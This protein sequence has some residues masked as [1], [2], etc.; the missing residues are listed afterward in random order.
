MLRWGEF[1][2]LR[3]DLAEAGRR[4]AEAPAGLA[5]QALFE[6]LVESCLWTATGGHGDWNPRHTVWRSG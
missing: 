2:R 6:F 3:P 4:L 5:D 1:Q